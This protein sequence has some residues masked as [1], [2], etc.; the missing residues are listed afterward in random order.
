MIQLTA[1]QILILFTIGC[2]TL[3]MGVAAIINAIV[4]VR[5]LNTVDRK[6]FRMVGIYV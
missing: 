2:F 5:K 3:L 1:V 6:S 4:S